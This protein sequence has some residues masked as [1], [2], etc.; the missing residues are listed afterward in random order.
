MHD[1]SSMK[2]RQSR[3]TAPLFAAPRLRTALLALALALP[4]AAVLPLDHGFTSNARAQTSI[5]VIVND[6]AITS[7]DVAQRARLL[8]LTTRR[9]AGASRKAAVEELIDQKLKLQE[10]SRLGISISDAQVNEAFA[11]IAQRTKMSPSQLSNALSRSGVKP[12]SLKER[13][14]SEMAW[15]EVARARF[16]QSIN[17]SEPEIIAALAKEGVDKDQKTTE[18][19]LQQ[20]IFVVPQKSSSG[21]KAKRQREANDLRQRFSSCEDGLKLANEY[22]EVV[23]KSLGIRLL[24]ELPPNIQSVLEGVDEGQL[25]KPIATGNGYEAFA[26]CKKR[27]VESDAAARN[28]VE[29]DLRNREGEMLARRFLRE[30][31]RDAIID[32]R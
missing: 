1:T 21:F 13:I 30:L 20:L 18:L 7:Y 10:A 29:V 28:K 22:S 12:D 3:R 15:G 9:S 8:Q 27:T 31:R 24:P 6:E 11:S 32:Y 4:A 23:V 25:S 2:F 26:V 17:V 16:R 14:R 5:T 19:T